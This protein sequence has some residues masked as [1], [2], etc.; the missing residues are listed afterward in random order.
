MTSRPFV[1]LSST[2]GAPGD[3]RRDIRAEIKRLVLA[4]ADVW[5]DEIDAPTSMAVF[6]TIDRLFG[7]ISR[8]DELIILMLGSA[9]GS[10][11]PIAGRERPAHVSFWEAELFYAA[12]STKPLSVFVEADFRP[13]PKLEQLLTVLQDALPRRRWHGPYDRRTIVAVVAEHILHGRRHQWARGTRATLR[14]MVEGFFRFRGTDGG[15]GTAEGESVRWVLSDALNPTVS[16][17][18]TVARRLLA[19]VRDSNEGGEEGRL[20]RLWLVYRE[21]TGLVSGSEAHT[22]ALPYWNQLYGAWGKAAS[23]Y[24]LHGHPSFGVLPALV[25]QAIMREQ[26][27][28]RL[29]LH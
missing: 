17:N 7:L 18:E 15:G 10:G 28:G 23:W 14:A 25:A 8:C 2:I 5:I 26:M 9:H 29:A 21:L 11:I 24:G 20:G 1:F 16:Y 6:T 19:Q 27:H 12:V 4:E 13:E 22:S 3:Y